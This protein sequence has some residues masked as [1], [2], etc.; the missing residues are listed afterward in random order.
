[1]S[2]LIFLVTARSKALKAWSKATLMFCKVIWTK[3]MVITEIMMPRVKRHK[4]DVLK[5]ILVF[6]ENLLVGMKLVIQRDDG[7]E[8]TSG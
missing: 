2:M 5:I 4:A 7:K 8:N 3:R 1:M 6:L